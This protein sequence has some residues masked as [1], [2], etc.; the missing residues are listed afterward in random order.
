MKRLFNVVIGVMLCG[1][2]FSALAATQAVNIPLY[3]DANKTSKVLEQLPMDIHLIPIF[4]RGD[5]LKVGDPRNGQTGWIDY[6]DYLKAQAQT[7]SQHTQVVYVQVNKE[8]K[9]TGD[10]IIAYQNGKKLS[11]ADA[12]VLYEKI[13]KQQQA[14]NQQFLQMQQQMNAMFTRSMQNMHQMFV[15]PMW[16]PIVIVNQDSSTP[17]KK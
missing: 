10:Q 2:V 15:Q 3:T 4:H 11:D 9:K 13:E 7:N 8:G 6:A 14:A 17:A 16:Q 12:K 1:F 5:W